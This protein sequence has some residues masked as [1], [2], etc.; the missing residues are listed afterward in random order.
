MAA[1]DFLEILFE[2]SA[3]IEFDGGYS[4][5]EAEQRAT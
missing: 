3:I 4:Q 2:R 1:S 5:H